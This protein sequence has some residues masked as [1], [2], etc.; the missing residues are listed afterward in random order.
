VLSCTE[1]NSG[2]SKSQVKLE[3][4]YRLNIRRP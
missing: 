2:A 1:V 4:A 3:V